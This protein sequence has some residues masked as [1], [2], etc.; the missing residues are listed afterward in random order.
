MGLVNFFKGTAGKLVER[1]KAFINRQREQQQ[2]RIRKFQQVRSKVK[3]VGKNALIGPIF[4][5]PKGRQKAKNV[6]NVVAERI[7]NP[8]TKVGRGINKLQST[9]GEFVG[10]RSAKTFGENLGD[11]VVLNADKIPFTSSFLGSTLSKRALQK[12]DVIKS[13]QVSRKELEKDFSLQLDNL[14]KDGKFQEATSLETQLQDKLGEI[15]QRIA[16]IAPITAKTKTQV[17]AENVEFALDLASLPLTL[18]GGG[19]AAKAGSAAA[20]KAIIK[21]VAT[22]QAL[23]GAGEGFARGVIGEAREGEQDPLKLGI[24]GFTGAGLGLMFFGGVKATGKVTKK[25][26]S[27]ITNVVHKN[28]QDKLGEISAQKFNG[29]DDIAKKVGSTEE[30]LHGFESH[31]N[32]ISSEIN[33]LE[34]AETITKGQLQE[35]KKLQKMRN[36]VDALLNEGEEGIVRYFEAKKPNASVLTKADP[37]LNDA[38]EAVLR[39]VREVTEERPMTNIEKE[40]VKRIVGVSDEQVADLDVK[41]ARDLVS[42][43]FRLDKFPDQAQDDIAQILLDN[44]GF[45]KQRRGVVTDEVAERMARELEPRAALKPGQTLNKE[46]SIALGN[47]LA[48]AQN[49]YQVL[50]DQFAELSR[51]PDPDV[52]MDLLKLDIQKTQQEI[53]ALSA[54]YFGARAEAGRAL[55]SYRIARKAF[56][57]R[58]VDL[59]TK[60]IKGDVISDKQI[61]QVSKHLAALNTPEE[62]FRFMRNMVKPT[63]RDW[64]GWYTYSNMLSSPKTQIRNIVGNMQNM[65]FRFAAKPFAVGIDSIATGFSKA[66]GGKREREVFLAELKPEMMG[67]MSGAQK[68][69]HKAMHMMRNGFTLDDVATGEFATRVE[70]IRGKAGAVFN[71]VSRL[72]EAGDLFFRSIAAEAELQS[73]AFALAKKKGLKG[74]DLLDEFKRL[75]DNPPVDLL[76]RVDAAGKDAVF[77]T[78]GGKFVQGLK[79]MRDVGAIEIITKKGKK[80]E[81]PAAGRFIV[82]FIETPANIMKKGVEASPAGF[83]TA[84]RQDAARDKSLVAGRAALGS[85]MLAPIAYLAANGQITGKGPQDAD[86]RQQLYDSGWRPNS[87][88]IGD[89]WV[90]YT[91]ILPLNLVLSAVGNAHDIWK[92]DKRGEFEPRDVAG[93]IA[94]V[95]G[96]VLDAS[97]LQGVN[98]LFNA[99]NDPERFGR[100]FTENAIRQLIPA[101]ALVGNLARSLDDTL[102]APESIIEGIKTQIPVLSKQVAPVIS[103]QGTPVKRPGTQIGGFNI[104]EFLSPERIGKK[105]DDAVLNELERIDYQYSTAKKKVHGYK[106]KGHTFAEYKS[107]RNMAIDT[108]TREVMKN[109]KWNNLTSSE[110]AVVLDEIQSEVNKSMK[111]FVQNS[112]ADDMIKKLNSLDSNTEKK[113]FLKKSLENKVI[114]NDIFELILQ[115]LLTQ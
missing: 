27:K 65:G 42:K 85:L 101:S 87:I 51:R 6:V 29:L 39:H 94:R 97:Y 68:G 91:N 47:A 111:V 14:R 44:G 32:R 37:S 1:G 58:D 5:T 54:S 79:K 102:R 109:P 48:N 82:P 36:E 23:T 98:N 86:L 104:T 75:A 2:E 26:T 28:L 53:G 50:V 35:F 74:D 80:I 73:G 22:H 24:G 106:M 83:L 63:L 113:K 105:R 13:L 34:E 71:S 84:L 38:Q 4:S 92:Y 30:F 95:G 40:S 67:M 52:N 108:L 46:E 16:R 59:I 90:P 19:A 31:R 64:M 45:T 10:F 72:L 57:T 66:I 18:I 41:R 8:K 112:A 61:E 115:K 15:D 93:L 96:S 11:Y 33:L 89:T 88:R 49:K 103:G 62:K 3:E 110:K 78:Q 56:E 20:K 7:R 60:A 9:V 43:K 76:R 25:A 100:R 77:R 99:L 69:F 17:L 107:R 55:Q 81:L 21:K 12:N 70:P 114:N